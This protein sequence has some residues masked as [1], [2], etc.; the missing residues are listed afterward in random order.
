MVPVSEHVSGRVL[1]NEGKKPTALKWEG[2]SY[3]LIVAVPVST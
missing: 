3:S 1:L 2:A